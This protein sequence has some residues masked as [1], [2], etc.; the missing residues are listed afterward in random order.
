MRQGEAVGLSADLALSAA[1]L[2]IEHR[3]PL[4]D[5]VILATARLHQATLWTQDGDFEGLDN[6][7]YRARPA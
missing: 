5:S 1:K 7:C 6:V 4:A 2:G 3:L